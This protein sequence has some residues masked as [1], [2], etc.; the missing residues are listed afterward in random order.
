M[1]TPAGELNTR[2]KAEAVLAQTLPQLPDSDFAKSKRALQQ[3]EMLNYLDQRNDDPK[4]FTWVAD[5]DLILGKVDRL[6]KR[7]S[8]SGH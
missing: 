6:C 4:P 8:R 2:A 5:A 3:P 7:I 1:I